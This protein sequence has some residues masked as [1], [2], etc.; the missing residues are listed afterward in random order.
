MSSGFQIFLWDLKA[1]VTQRCN[2]PSSSR[3]N[4]SCLGWGEVLQERDLSTALQ[5]HGHVNIPNLYIQR[6]DSPISSTGLTFSINCNW[7]WSNLSCSLI[8]QKCFHYAIGH[9]GEMYFGRGLLHPASPWGS[10]PYGTTLLCGFILLWTCI[11]SVKQYVPA[12]VQII[13]FF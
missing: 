13:L 10:I 3:Q 2:S 5:Y 11:S 9:N 1:S 6:I 4:W 12:L 8:W 7:Y